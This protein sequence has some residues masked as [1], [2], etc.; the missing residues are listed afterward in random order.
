MQRKI[1][2][3]EDADILTELKE[4]QELTRLKTNLEQWIKKGVQQG[5]LKI[6]PTQEMNLDSALAK[7]ILLEI[8]NLFEKSMLDLALPDTTT[9][10]F[11]LE[12]I[13]GA[14]TGLQKQ[15]DKMLRKLKLLKE[16]FESAIWY[17]ESDFEDQLRR[18]LILH[19]DENS[20]TELPYKAI[21]QFA[22][23]KGP[24]WDKY[25][26]RQKEFEASMRQLQG[27]YIEDRK[28]LETSSLL[29]KHGDY[30]KANRVLAS[31]LGSFS[32]L[33]YNVVRQ[34]ISKWKQKALEPYKAFARTFRLQKNISN[35]LEDLK[36]VSE[37]IN[38]ALQ[39][40]T[41]STFNPFKL[42]TRRRLWLKRLGTY[43]RMCSENIQQTS[44]LNESDFSKDLKR[45]WVKGQKIAAHTKDKD[46]SVF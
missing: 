27:S 41:Y 18:L 31:T 30:R 29:S 39:K 45:R 21:C 40:D 43:R 17:K 13:E 7:E 36:N 9:Q 23:Q 3:L 35:S 25:V 11:R 1:N 4:I 8:F 44:G 32:E 46:K 10:M 34:N 5:K 26:L 12:D 16:K 24:F 14:I 19:T 42:L 37:K 15:N 6:E 33:P 28:K 38:E 2:Y 22:L 20:E